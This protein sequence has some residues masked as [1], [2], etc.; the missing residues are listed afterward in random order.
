MPPKATQAVAGFSAPADHDS[1]SDTSMDHNADAVEEPSTAGM[2]QAAIMQVLLDR[3]AQLESRNER[4][5]S[6]LKLGFASS[7][8]RVREPDVFSGNRNKLRAFISQCELYFKLHGPTFFEEEDKILFMG[9]LL[10]DAAYDWYDGLLRNENLPDTYEAFVK[11]LKRTYGAIDEVAG[12]ERAIST[13]KQ[14]HS[15]SQYASDFQQLSSHLH[16]DDEALGFQFYTGLKENIKDELARD[17]RPNV[18]EDLIE[19]AVKID[20]RI[21]ERYLERKGGSTRTSSN[22]QSNRTGFQKP[23]PPPQKPAPAYYGL[24]PMELDGTEPPRGPL[25]AAEKAHRLLHHL[26]LYCG[27]PG[28]GV[29]ECRLA[30]SNRKPSHGFQ[31]LSTT[32]EQ[33]PSPN[34]RARR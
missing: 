19:K 25:T 30:M 5:E 23:D 4:P 33:P 12:A 6:S 21:Y 32:T 3:I 8:P 14:T 34:G 2:S 13:L 11:A 16:W 29:K 20:N 7:K 15:A 24:Q 27:K 10:R 9:T 28:H 18:L 22:F 17:G 26:C 1:A 31:R